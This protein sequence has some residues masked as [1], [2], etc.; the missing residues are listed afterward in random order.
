[1][2]THAFFVQDRPCSDRIVLSKTISA[3]EAA[4][5]NDGAVK[6]GLLSQLHA[7]TIVERCG[8]GFTDR[9]VKVRTQTA[10][11]FVFLQDLESQ[12]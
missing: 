7:G 1:M 4:G 6:L 5:T 12:R 8:N 3:I 11:Y 9:T 2:N 10:Y